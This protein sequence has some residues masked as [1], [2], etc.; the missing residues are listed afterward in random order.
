MKYLPSREEQG[1]LDMVTPKF[2][3]QNFSTFQVIARNGQ[4]RKSPNII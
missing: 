4:Q 3:D 2:G 1:L